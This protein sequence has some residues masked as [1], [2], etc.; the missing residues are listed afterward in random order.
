MLLLHLADGAT[1]IAVLPKLDGKQAEE[2]VAILDRQR[3]AGVHHG[4]HFVIRQADHHAQTPSFVWTGK[5][6]LD[7]AI[8]PLRH[9]CKN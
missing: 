7:S 3:P 6:P 8:H 5:V 4:S 2:A 9:P 1:E